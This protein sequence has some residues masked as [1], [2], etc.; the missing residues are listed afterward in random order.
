MKVRFEVRKGERRT[1]KCAATSGSL[2]GSQES[3]EM[4]KSRKSKE[5]APYNI[6][7]RD[8]DRGK[9]CQKK[10]EEKLK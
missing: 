1:A 2:T 6:P 7:P 10:K 3:Q 5:E 8:A 9:E 4:S